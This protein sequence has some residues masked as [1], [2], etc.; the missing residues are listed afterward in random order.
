M[1]NGPTPHPPHTHTPVDLGGTYYVS[2]L[3]RNTPSLGNTD[4]PFHGLF[5]IISTLSREPFL[6][7][8]PPPSSG[9]L[10]V[11]P[12][13]FL[14]FSFLFFSILFLSSVFGFFFR[15]DRE[16]V[17]A[18]YHSFLFSFS[19]FFSF[20]LL[21]F[22]FLFFSLLFFYFIFLFFSF[23]FF[24]YFLAFFSFLF[25]S[26]F[27]FLLF[28]FFFSFLFSSLLFYFIFLF[29]FSFRFF[30]LGKYCR[31]TYFTIAVTPFPKW[32]GT[33]LP[34]GSYGVSRSHCLT[35]LLRDGITW[36]CDRGMSSGPHF[37]KGC[38]QSYHGYQWQIVY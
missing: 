25:F 8:P 22:S 23:L 10:Q 28:S 19:L 13:L 20:S 17:Y 15:R 33:W 24:F 35:W 3:S 2:S 16:K 38:D 1:Y 29:F 21:F 14:F 9:T 32:S 18:F 4:G 26:L 12:I 36:R 34:R 5:H 7:E 6:V 11:I 37:T 30:G 31:P 27:S